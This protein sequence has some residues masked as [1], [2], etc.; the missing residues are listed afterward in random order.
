[1]TDGE[2]GRSCAGCLKRGIDCVPSKSGRPG[3]ACGACAK[4]HM[5]CSWKEERA[6][7][8]VSGGVEEFRRVVKEEISRGIGSDLTLI[9]RRITSLEKEVWNILKGVGGRD[10]ID[11]E[12]EE[13]WEVLQNWELWGVAGSGYEHLPGIDPKDLVRKTED[14]GIE[15][16]EGVE[17]EKSKGKAKAK[18]MEVDVEDAEMEE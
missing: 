15:E 14:D 2:F 9:K 3:Q 16:E 17:T 7:S 12:W 18:E 8:E 1:V 5:K 4:A 13:R 10:E 6:E 11:G